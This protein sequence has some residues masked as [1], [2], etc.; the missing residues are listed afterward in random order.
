[1]LQTRI[2][3]GRELTDGVKQ[4][5]PE[6]PLITIIT[7]TFNAAKD[8]H[9]TIESIR[10]QTYPHIQWIIADGASTDGTVEILKQNED[11]IDYWFSE[12]DKG[13]Y[14]AWN[15]ALPYIKGEWVQFLGAGDELTDSSVYQNISVEL[16]NYINQYDLIYGSIEIISYESRRHIERIGESWSSLKF[17]WQGFRPAL[18]VHPEV[19]HKASIFINGHK[20]DEK[21]KIAADSKLLLE[22]INNDNILFIDRDVVRMPFG[23]VSTDIS[24]SLLV[25]KELLSIC[26]DLNISQDK[27]SY[28]WCSIKES[29]KYII[30]KVLGQRF[31]CNVMDIARFLCG[32]RRKWTVK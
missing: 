24:H 17:Q 18:P 10:A 2:E 12:P 25:R 21:Y 32:R 26:Q 22:V 20:F 7:S 13:I 23:G 30:F 19:F 4:G 1:M 14:H 11:I 29:S 5:T 31:F 15:K 9:W 27:F 8:L 16:R 6:Q 28:I 3:G